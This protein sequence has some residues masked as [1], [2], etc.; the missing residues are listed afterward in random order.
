MNVNDDDAMI[1]N[2]TGLEYFRYYICCQVERLKETARN[3]SQVN[4]QT[5][6]S[7]PQDGSSELYR[8]SNRLGFKDRN[9]EV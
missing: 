1:W 3:F 4:T 9:Y 7:V 2:E 8:E 6:N 5:L